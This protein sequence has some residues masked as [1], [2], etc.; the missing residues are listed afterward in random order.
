MSAVADVDNWL[1]ELK[2]AWKSRDVNAAAKLFEHTVKYYE[3]PFEPVTSQDEIYKLW[4]EILDTHDITFDYEIA[5][6]TENAKGTRAFVRW[7]NAYTVTTTGERDELDGVF[8]LD[9]DSKGNCIEFHMWWFM[10]PKV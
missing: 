4:Q 7:Q 1:A 6:I 5:A 10:K 9:F 8:Q 2:R 3:R